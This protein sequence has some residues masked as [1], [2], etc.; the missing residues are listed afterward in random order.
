MTRHGPPKLRL[1]LRFETLNFRL[2]LVNKF[3]THNPI[4]SGLP[5]SKGEE[6]PE[7]SSHRHPKEIINAKPRRNVP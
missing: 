4:K 5:S 6:C 2:T 7:P 1:W 3:W